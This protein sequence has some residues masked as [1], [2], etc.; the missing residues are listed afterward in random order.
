M[1]ETRETEKPVVLLGGGHAHV[2]V[3]RALGEHGHGR[4]IVLV[5]P[6]RHA[7][8]SGMLPGY[9]AGRYRFEDF[10]IDLAALCDRNDVTFLETS[11]TGIDPGRRSV[12]LANGRVVGYDLLSVDIGSAPSLPAGISGGIPVK[13]IASFAERLAQLDAL[14]EEHEGPFRLAIVGQGVAGVEM[15]FALRERF[16]RGRVQVTLAGRALRPV[17]ERSKRTRKFVETALQ[18]A[19]IEHYSG[20]DVVA[21]ENRELIAGD[22]RR[23]PVDEAVWTTSSGAPAWL[24]KTGLQ[25]DAAGFIRVDAALRSVSHGNV[26]AAGDVASLP[27]PRPKAGVFAVRQGPI[28]ADN[29]RRSLEGEDLLPFHPQRAWLALISLSN[30]R[31]IADK[32]G[33]SVS[34]RGVQAWK[35]WNDTRFLKKYACNPHRSR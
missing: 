12:S 33:L 11:A 24:R 19:G 16:A 2:E 30:G 21:F 32:W 31:A 17:P 9:I 8:Y 27:D 14:A 13:P 26:F 28:L 6:S 10:H 5:S 7:P 15:A 22:G 34:G 23:L 29:I 25:L 3:V 1:P 20:F 18:K 35:H 4:K